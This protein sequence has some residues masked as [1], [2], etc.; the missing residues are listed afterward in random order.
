M[1][2]LQFGND[3]LNI[4]W[5][6]PWNFSTKPEDSLPSFSREIAYS[7]RMPF[8]ERVSCLKMTVCIFFKVKATKL[9]QRD[10]GH[11]HSRT[12]CALMLSYLRASHHLSWE[13][14]WNGLHLER[15]GCIVGK[16]FFL[17]FQ[18]L[19]QTACSLSPQL[20]WRA[21]F[22]FYQYGGYFLLWLY[23]PNNIHF[24]L[25]TL[26]F[27]LKWTER[28]TLRLASILQEGSGM[29]DLG[30]KSGWKLSLSLQLVLTLAAPWLP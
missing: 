17:Y 19:Q 15:S 22:F 1:L 30:L 7:H 4:W 18:S 28:I 2:S 10:P 3:F 27:V 24:R 14:A 21:F 13:H 26:F 25:L 12:L 5:L 23:F 9:T 20:W 16:D 8:C 29:V 11:K 6:S